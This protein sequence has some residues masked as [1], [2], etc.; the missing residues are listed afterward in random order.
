MG[1]G[2]GGN[3]SFM[4]MSQTFSGQS[5]TAAGQMK[6]GYKT[7]TE[8]TPDIGDRL[9]AGMGMGLVGMQ[10]AP[11]VAGALGI[12][13]GAAAGTAAAAAGTTAAAGGGALAGAAT[14]SLAIPVWGLAIGAVLGI[15]ST[16]F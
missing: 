9:S 7:E 16:F 8:S 4:D 6:A 3:R 15:A 10:M 13:G 5:I 1:Y 14:A 12:G 11:T 2:L